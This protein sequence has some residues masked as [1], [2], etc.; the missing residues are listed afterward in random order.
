VSRRGTTDQ[1]A[2]A[3]L[4]VSRALVGVAA[5]SL[6]VLDEDVTLAQYRA[7]VVLAASGPQLVGA[8]AGSLAIH[9]S[10]ATRLC[11]RLV[12]KGLVERTA[13]AESRREVLVSLSTSGRA[14]LDGVTASRLA[15]IR[16]IVAAIPPSEWPGILAAFETF[17]AAA[18]EVPDD[19]WLL[20]WT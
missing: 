16:R 2:S 20:G 9:P 1:V 15:E 17:A 11:D 7:L 10:T 14:V 3:V 19:A 5:R 6:S 13:S 18:G 8:L 4:T 12:R